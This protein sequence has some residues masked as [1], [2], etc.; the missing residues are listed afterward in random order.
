MFIQ[1]TVEGGPS[2]DSGATLFCQG[3]A[4]DRESLSRLMVATTARAKLGSLLAR[5]RYGGQRFVIEQRGEPAVVMMGYED[6]H[7]AMDLLED[8][9]DIRDIL[10]SEGEP[11]R[12]LRE[13]LAQQGAPGAVRTPR[14]D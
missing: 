1:Q 10:E 3:Q 6:Y 14:G 13:Y 12:P 11:A 5:A 2:F 8:L 7:A 4:G 9:E